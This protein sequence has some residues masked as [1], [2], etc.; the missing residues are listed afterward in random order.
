MT[1]DATRESAVPR[2]RPYQAR[3]A[4]A[5]L[6]R[7]LAGDGGSISV[8]IARQGGKNEL[9]AQTE[10]ALLLLHAEAGGTIVKCA[11]T[12]AQS[13]ISQLRLM[14]RAQQA[15]LGY[16]AGP[17]GLWKWMKGG[18]KEVLHTPDQVEPLA[19]LQVPP[20]IVR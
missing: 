18:G 20:A 8:E 10:L 1:A 3:V 6:R 19:L 12:L 17:K 11:P 4:R 14:R 7:V 16:A 15:G 13:R 2:L 5:I 9:S